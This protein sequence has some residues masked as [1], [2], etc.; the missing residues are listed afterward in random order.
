MDSKPDANSHEHVEFAPAARTDTAARKHDGTVRLTS[1]Q[2]GVILIPT[3]SLDPRDP[4]NMPLWQKLV[5]LGTTSMYSTMGL[6]PVSGLGGLLVF[7]IPEYSAQG[8]TYNDISAL[9]TYPSLFMGLGNI[10]S[11][12][13]ALA[14]GR[15]PVLLV[16][17][18]IQVVSLILCATNQS[19]S[20]HFAA[21]C[22]LGLAAGQ[23]EAL[24]PLIISEIFFL[25]ERGKYQQLFSTIQT[26]ISGTLILLTSYIAATIGWRAWYYLFAGFSGLVLVFVALFVAETKYDRPLVAY[27]GADTAESASGLPTQDEIDPEALKGAHDIITVSDE[28]IIDSVNYPPRT[29]LSNTRIFVNK[30]DWM[31]AV[32]CLK[33]MAQLFFFPN[34]AWVYAMNGV[35]LGVNIATG[36]TYGNILSGNFGW[37]DKYISVAQAGQIVVAF[38]CVPMLGYGSDWI[39]K[40]AARRNRGI[41]EPEFRLWTLPI[42][43]LLGCMFIVIYGQ[44]AAF[45]QNYHWAAIVV[46]ING[47]Y[48]SFLGANTA[49]ITYLLDAFP[50]R[51]ASALVLLC[52]MR[53]VISFSLS[54]GTVSMYEKYG[55]DGAFGLFGG[56][57]AIFGLLGV[58]VY[59][60]GKRLRKFVSPWTAIE[61]TSK[62]TMG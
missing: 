30:P 34:V 38:I 26:A 16:S 17:C 42:P 47:Y 46:S 8:K 41:H 52:A 23:S 57:T 13:I 35:F 51:A 29:M 20:W 2:G 25:H 5:C 21:R 45:P 12:P 28:R 31:E 19:Y 56:I 22:I 55:Y 61:I 6:V 50:T 3:P 53:G 59:M 62:A 27:K 11:M 49:G 43:L 24:C 33:H 48:F 40:L 9:L 58:V 32:H 7:F 10:I 14:V 1:D 15:R 37:A 39:V 4:L 44:A 36:L 54:Y 18:V 60:T